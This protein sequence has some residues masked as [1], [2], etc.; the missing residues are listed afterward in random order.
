LVPSLNFAAKLELIL[1]ISA[2]N[3]RIAI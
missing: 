1:K 3:I 2:Y